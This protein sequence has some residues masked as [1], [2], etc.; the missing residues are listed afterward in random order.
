MLNIVN[1]GRVAMAMEKAGYEVTYPS[2]RNDLS[3][4]SL[5]VSARFDD[6]NGRPYVVELHN[7]QRHVDEMLLEFKP[8]QFLLNIVASMRDAAKLSPQHFDQSI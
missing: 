6:D 3:N 1:A 4:G 2:G 8:L 5:V 7:L